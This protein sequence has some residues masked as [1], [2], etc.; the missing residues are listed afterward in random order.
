MAESNGAFM[1]EHEE[2]VETPKFVDPGRPV[3]LPEI[4][5]S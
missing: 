4:I 5:D 2:S 1:I 3:H